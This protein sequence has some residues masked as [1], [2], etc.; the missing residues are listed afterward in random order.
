MTK[1]MNSILDINRSAKTTIRNLKNPRAITAIF[2]VIMIMVLF[3][4]VLRLLEGLVK[5]APQIVMLFPI[6]GVGMIILVL[7]LIMFICYQE[8]FCNVNPLNP[9]DYI[10]LLKK[11]CNALK[12]NNFKITA[13]DL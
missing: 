7:P 9:K 5:K 10:M 12:N 6:C 11:T 4:Y 2:I 1:Q 13:K 8:D 3:F